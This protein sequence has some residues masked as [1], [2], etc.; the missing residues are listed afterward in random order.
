MVFS[1]AKVSPRKVRIECYATLCSAPPFR[2]PKKTKISQRLPS[3]SAVVA[4]RCDTV[5]V[6]GAPIVQMQVELLAA[7]LHVT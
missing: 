5:S 2:T 7:L 1:F 3:C 6:G 4:G